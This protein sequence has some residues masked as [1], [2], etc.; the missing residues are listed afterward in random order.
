MLYIE[1]SGLYALLGVFSSKASRYCVSFNLDDY[2]ESVRFSPGFEH[3]ENPAGHNLD[4][5]QI[6]KG[7]GDWRTL[8]G[9]N[10]CLMF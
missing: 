7:F 8:S 9:F 4:R 6:L 3:G 10:D 2:A 1:L 5:D